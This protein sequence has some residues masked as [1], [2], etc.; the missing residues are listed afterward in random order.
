[1]ENGEWED[2]RRTLRRRNQPLYDEL[3]KMARRHADAANAANPRPIEG[4]IFSMLLEQL[5]YIKDLEEEIEELQSD[6]ETMAGQVD[7]AS[8][9]SDDY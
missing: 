9:P 6:V 8:S 4:A 7:E 2:Y 3:W 1:M 5:R